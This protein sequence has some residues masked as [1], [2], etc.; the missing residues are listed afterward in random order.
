M[1]LLVSDFD[2]TLYDQNYDD[3]I[4]KVNEFV[5]KGNIFVIA[6]GRPYS[7]LE[8]LIKDKNILYEYLICSDGTIVLDKNGNII[9]KEVLNNE[10]VTSIIPLLKQDIN[11]ENVY[12]DTIN[13]EVFGLYGLFNNETM[14][15]QL[16]KYLLNNYEVDGYLSARWLNIIKKDITKVN[17]IEYLQKIL[18][19]PDND[20]LTVGDNINDFSMIEK[21]KGYRISNQ[22]KEKHLDSFGTFMDIIKNSFE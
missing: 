18:S 13:N 15:N 21:Y 3:N 19:I 7:L 9:N 6:T 11:I 17:G 22:Q 1:K 5:K 8:P 14:A 12:V 16:L 10:L 2:L 20:V 4:K